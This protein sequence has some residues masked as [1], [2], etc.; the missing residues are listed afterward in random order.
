MEVSRALEGGRTGR[1]RRRFGGD[2]KDS[3]SPTSQ[4]QQQ[5]GE[6]NDGIDI[7]EAG[8]GNE[9]SVEMEKKSERKEVKF[10]KDDL[11]WMTGGREAKASSVASKAKPG[12]GGKKK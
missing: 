6:S 10:E 2:E 8:I 12:K 1:F 3:T 7:L 4:Q 5:K 9:K 11:D